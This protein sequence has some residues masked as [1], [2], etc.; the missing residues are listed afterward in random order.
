MV[1]KYTQCSPIFLIFNYYSKS[2]FHISNT[3]KVFLFFFCLSW[4]INGWNFLKKKKKKKKKKL[5]LSNFNTI[6]FFKI[7]IPMFFK[8]QVIVSR[9]TRNP[10]KV[11][12]PNYKY[13]QKKKKKKKKIMDPNTPG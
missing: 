5:V 11:A 9:I 10:Y 2:D 4:N 1:I 7:I 8:K 3:G 12:L 13:F 6:F